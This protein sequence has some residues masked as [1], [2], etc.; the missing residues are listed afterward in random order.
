VSEPQLTP[1]SSVPETR[2][3]RSPNSFPL[4]IVIGLLAGGAL[5]V[6]GAFVALPMLATAFELKGFRSPTSSM[7]PTIC[8][9]E[10]FIVSM[11][12]YRGRNPKRGD[13]VM[14]DTPQSPA[15]FVKRV[16]GIPG[17]T[18]SPGGHNEVLVNGSPLPQPS[19][20]GKPLR[21]DISGSDNP[22]FQ[23]V[24]IP[25]G[26]LFVVGDNLSNSY[27]SR[28][29]GLVALHQVK[30]KPL[31]LYWSPGTSRIGCPIR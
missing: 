31:F 7:C 16:I 4:K 2:S 12:A 1:S 28:F 24:K 9:D 21:S 10:F 5:L 30:G 13:V 18:V 25:E 29:Y 27:D 15:P 17:D 22:P 23:A 8:I 3:K 14:H 6:V 19:V 11:N 20:C 26:Y